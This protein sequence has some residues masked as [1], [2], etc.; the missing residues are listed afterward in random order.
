M[1]AVGDTATGN[2]ESELSSIVVSVLKID[3]GENCAGEGEEVNVG[4]NAGVQGNFGEDVA[5]SEMSVG[6]ETGEGTTAGAQGPVLLELVVAAVAD[7]T[8]RLKTRCREADFGAATKLRGE[9]LF[10][11]VFFTCKVVSFNRGCD[12]SQNRHAKTTDLILCMLRRWRT[13]P[14][15]SAN[16]LWSGHLLHIFSDPSNGKVKIQSVIVKKC[17]LECGT[18]ELWRNCM[19]EF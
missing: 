11:W 17:C 10:E 14:A 5:T 9:S 3:C 19:E 15:W 1:V 13:T 8:E 18:E 7:G 16:G 4:T 6:T 2:V 12:Q